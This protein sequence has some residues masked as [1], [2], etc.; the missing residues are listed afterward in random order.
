MS[1]RFG[2]ITVFTLSSRTVGLCLENEAADVIRGTL[3]GGFLG[4]RRVAEDRC[5]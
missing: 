3:N 2:I 5:V 4:V 1:V